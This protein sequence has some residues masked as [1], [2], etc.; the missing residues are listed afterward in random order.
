M[1]GTTKDAQCAE[2]H[3]TAWRVANDLRGSLDGWDFKS[4]GSTRSSN[5]FFGLSN[6]GDK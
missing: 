1:A 5:G 4:Y 2:P 3:T 6:Q